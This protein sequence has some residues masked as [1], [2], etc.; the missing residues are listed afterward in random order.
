MKRE[1]TLPGKTLRVLTAL[2]LIC[3]T[4]TAM[5]LP[6]FA[7]ELKTGIGIVETSGLRL[8]AKPNTDCEILAN[9]SY[10]DSVVII[11]D[12]GDFYLVD[13]NLQIG[14]MAKQYI[15]FKERE[16]IELGYA[17]VIDS[18]VNMRSAPSSDGELLAQLMP[19]DQPYIIG[20]NCGWYKVTFGGDTGYIRSDLL[21]LTQAPVGNSGGSMVEVVSLGQQ[22]VDLAQ[23]YLG[24]P[25]VWGGSTPSG[26]FDCSGFVKY[27]YA[28][29]GY[30]LNRV[31]A[32]QM[33]NGHIDRVQIVDHDGIILRIFQRPVDQHD[34]DRADADAKLFSGRVLR[35]VDDAVDV[36]AREKFEL[37]QLLLAVKIVAADEALV[38]AAAQ[39]RL[40][41]RHDAPEERAGD[42]RQENAD[43]HRPVGLEAAGKHVDGK[44]QL[45]DRRVDRK[46]VLLADVAAVEIFGNSGQRKPGPAGDVLD[47]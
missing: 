41:R 29:M 21:E 36:V 47:R 31:A 4:L 34:R 8:R 44:A 32:D 2:L 22:V 7:I 9:A 27:V 39:H 11:R 26:G 18:A 23:N 40:H 12:A 33:L 5:T 35:D 1:R 25:Y 45:R 3:A 38:A 28:Q 15:T 13:Y 46:A 30:T 20:F 6:A 42:R 14:Y 10:G 37:F 19:G 43:G 24:Y 17:N 16:N